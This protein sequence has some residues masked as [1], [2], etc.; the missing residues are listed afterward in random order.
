MHFQIRLKCLTLNYKGEGQ[1]RGTIKCWGALAH[2]GPSVAA[3]LSSI[4]IYG[5]RDSY[6]C[7]ND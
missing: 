7:S 2:P 5:Y 3:P 1:R 6:T 4:R